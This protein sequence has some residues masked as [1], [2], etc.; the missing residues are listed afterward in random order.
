MV[1]EVYD[2]P[3]FEKWAKNNVVLVEIDFPRRSKLSEDIQKQNRE[4][5][6]M[7]GVRGYPTIWFVKPETKN[8]ASVNLS[9]LG[10]TGYVAGGPTKW[11]ESAEKILSNK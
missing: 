8:Q 9:Q 1:K 7:F 10:S 6:Q 5:Q 11:I 2:K 3:E 4:L